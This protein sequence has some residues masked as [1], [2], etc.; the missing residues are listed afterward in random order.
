MFLRRYAKF[1]AAS[2]SCYWYWV[3]QGVKSAQGTIKVL[4][5]SDFSSDLTHF[6]ATIGGRERALPKR[7]KVTPLIA[8]IR[9]ESGICH[10]RVWYLYTW[11]LCCVSSVAGQR[12][13]ADHADH[14]RVFRGPRAAPLPPTGGRPHTLGGKSPNLPSTTLADSLHQLKKVRVGISAYLQSWRYACSITQTCIHICMSS[15]AHCSL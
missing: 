2:L 15:G 6:H 5:K 14:G 3:V 12:E 9:L 4:L 11:C 13:G 7:Y 10:C 1:Q 8:E